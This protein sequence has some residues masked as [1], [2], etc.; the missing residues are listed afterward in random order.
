MA[1]LPL[2]EA[3][4]RFQQNE[5]R[6]DKFVNDPTGYTSSGGQ[7]VES[8]PAFLERVETDIQN[9]TGA[10]A[11]NVSAAQSAQAAAE[12][13]RDAAQLSAG[14]YATTTA[15]L[16]ATTNG[17]YF[18]V[19]SANAN[20]YLMLYKNNA[21]VADL[22]NTYP[23][24][25]GVRS[26]SEEVKDS[27][28]G[29]GGLGFYTG[30][31]DLVP[32]F[33]DI[34]NNILLAYK[35]SESRIVGLGIGTEGIQEF[36]GNE[37]QAEYV[38][39]G[40]IWPIVTDK[41]NR[42]I[43]G[44]DEENDRIVAAGIST[45]L[46]SLAFAD[47][48]ALDAGDAPIAKA[49]NHLLLYG[50]SLSVGSAAGGI[51]STSQPYSNVTWVSGPRA[52]GSD[53]SS[54]IPLIE[55]V[56]ST[57]GETPCS[58]AANYA[59]TLMAVEDGIN[60]S[61]HV[62]LASTAGLGGQP[63]VN[64]K[65]GSSQYDNEFLS[66]IT[67]GKA[68]NSNYALHAV[69]WI[70]GENDAVTTKQTPY[71]EYRA[72][73]E[74]LQVDIETDA[75]AISGQTSPVFMI[76]YQM[77]YAAAT[78]PYM[79]FAQL[80]LAQKNDRFYITTPCYHLQFATDNVHLTKEGYKHLGAYFGRAYK[81]LVI[82][83]IKPQWLNPVSATRRGN[84]IRVRF[85]VPVLPLVFDTT[86][87]APTTDYGFRVTD[88]GANATISDKL[89]DGNEV[90]L[91]LSAVPTGEVKVRYAIDYLGTGLS[92]TGGASGNLRDSDPE[93][94]TIAGVPKPLYHV[95]PHFELTVISLGE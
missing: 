41:F 37:G 39:D 33:I 38:G 30:T 58:G 77:S 70:Q 3:V 22:V 93:T 95:C 2:D 64:L 12:A 49:L 72:N 84:V 17:E 78:W 69:G 13:A 79:A 73:L 52:D 53:Y 9:T 82:D 36:L 67:N 27:L 91:T 10:I 86:T 1:Q 5:D 94:V 7:V 66:H 4:S 89:I 28:T 31:D 46:S 59:S 74:Q 56:S 57:L 90:V 63:I 62:I 29:S 40:P 19:P 54:L 26:S 45:P 21:G 92:F 16:A 61:S 76:T 80:D 25:Q 48:V 88:G 15:G 81:Q 60:P 85:E 20:E 65:K 6:V 75:K 34:N 8:L 14:V 35:L 87:M 71:A 11:S 23:S 51:L 24:A 50:Q 68:R 32:L 18:S 47:D 83:G 42:V 43:L 44:Y 55:T